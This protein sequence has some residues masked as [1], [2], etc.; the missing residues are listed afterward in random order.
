M[1]QQKNSTQTRKFIFLVNVFICL[2]FLISCQPT[3]NDNAAPVAGEVI[4][5]ARVTSLPT[6]PA[7]TVTPTPASTSRAAVATAT[8]EPTLTHTPKPPSTDTPKPTPTNSPWQIDLSSPF[9]FF[10]SSRNIMVGYPD[11]QV[12]TITEGKIGGIQPWSPDGTKFIF[13]QSDSPTSRN[14]F[15]ADLET[16]EV[17]SVD[18]PGLWSPDGE[19]IFSSEDGTGNDVLLVKYHIES[20]TRTILDS[21]PRKSQ[22]S[23][24]NLVG[25]SPD[26]KKVAY[27]AEIDGQYDLFVVDTETLERQQLTNDT[28]AEVHV[29]WSPTENQLFVS[30]HPEAT[31]FYSYPFNAYNLYLIDELGNKQLISEFERLTQVSW[32]PDGQQVAVSDDGLL[33]LISIDDFSRTCPLEDVLPWSDHDVAFNDPAT[34]SPDG[35]WL[36]FQVLSGPLYCHDSYV[37]NLLSG[38][39]VKLGGDFCYQA[40]FL[41]SPFVP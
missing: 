4:S 21:F 16:G 27:V 39:L 15:F 10:A 17:Q 14:Y 38:E 13:S 9:F 35:Q 3:T 12:E 19:Y 20:R 11:G 1:N 24:Y 6:E 40:H 41:W 32:A 25:W 22:N 30:T 5:T 34:Y 28:Q 7:L 2:V 31:T 8:K 18:L 26:S 33:C 37:F 36:A 23:Y 29:A